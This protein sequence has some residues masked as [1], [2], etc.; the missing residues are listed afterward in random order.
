MSL[1]IIGLDG[2]TWDMID[3]NLARLPTLAKVKERYGH[4][5]LVCDVLAH[6]APAWTTCFTGLK[7]EEHGVYEFYRMIPGRR[8]DPP[9]QQRGKPLRREDIEARFIWE[10]LE[11]AQ[12]LKTAALTIY[13]TV[14]PTN[15]NCH[16][17][18]A[19][20]FTLSLTMAEVK[21]A[22]ERQTEKVLELL[23]DGVDFLATVFIG[24]D[25]A[26]HVWKRDP[27][28]IQV[29]R[30]CDEALARI[31]PEVDDWM[32]VSDHG[33]PSLRVTGQYGSS[34]PSHDP[35][36]I[37]LCSWT[38]EVPRRLSEVTPFIRAYYDGLDQE[39]VKERLCALGY[40]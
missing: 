33:Y 36:G 5:T 31:L 9:R 35:R 24:P 2:M 15:H 26:H 20:P 38:H 16:Y 6:S 17:T 4:G 18:Q 7:P 19:L 25:K 3:P 27:E 1:A 23:A 11:E 14:P 13:C 28:T 29:Y 37:V 34:V 39:H 10:E 8:K 22:T 40:L 21:E 12:G 32:I 30:W